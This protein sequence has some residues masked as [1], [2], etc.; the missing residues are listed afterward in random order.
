M[1]GYVGLGE[2]SNYAPTSTGGA[3]SVVADTNTPGDN[4][5]GVSGSGVTN[6]FSE[7]PSPIPAGA[8]RTRSN[9]V[10]YTRTGEILQVRG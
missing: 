8:L 9:E 3:I 2:V 1:P 6:T 4:G 10:L 5:A 7:A